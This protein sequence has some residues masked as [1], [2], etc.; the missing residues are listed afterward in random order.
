M[1]PDTSA[2]KTASVPKLVYMR[3]VDDTWRI[4][5]GICGVQVR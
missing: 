5:S 4:G 3:A 2:G 1:F